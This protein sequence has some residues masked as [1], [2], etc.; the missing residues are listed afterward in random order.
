[1]IKILSVIVIVG[2]IAISGLVVGIKTFLL[3]RENSN[4]N[5]SK[6]E[7]KNIF[8]PK[9]DVMIFATQTNEVITLDGVY[10]GITNID[11]ENLSNL[12]HFYT[13][14]LVVKNSIPTFA[15]NKNRIMRSAN[16]EGD[17]NK[18]IALNGKE[19]DYASSEEYDPFKEDTILI[20][21]SDKSLSA[22]SLPITQTTIHVQGK[23][24]IAITIDKLP[25]E[26]QS[27]KPVGFSFDNSKLYIIADA[28]GDK[29]GVRSGFYEYTIATGE[30]KEMQ[31]TSDSSNMDG[32]NKEAA[33]SA[34]D[35]AG[36]F[37]YFLSKDTKDKAKI[38][39]M[40]ITSGKYSDVL[41]NLPIAS[42]RIHFFNNGESMVVDDLQEQT[43]LYFVDL[44]N[45]K[46]Q[47]L[48]MIGAFYDVLSN[49]KD[50]I[51]RKDVSFTDNTGNVNMRYNVVEY[52]LYSHDSG[53]DTPVLNIAN[54]IKKNGV[55]AVSDRTTILGIL[56]PE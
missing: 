47:E 37:I 12:V 8:T 26:M 21:S 35:A 44:E 42:W 11:D 15:I 56:R 36:N 4:A 23:K 18:V 48:P 38:I 39:R 43:H 53:K 10:P 17:V 45:N 41:V 19:V 5:I 6:N 54:S 1:M 9:K 46:T 55:E 30:V 16:S 29:N 13:Y 7:E 2:V 3:K 52:H 50:F 14:D 33:F 51:Y 31:Y 34:I 49:G 22:E 20:Y 24:N 28:I 40:E 32:V 27:M 25:H